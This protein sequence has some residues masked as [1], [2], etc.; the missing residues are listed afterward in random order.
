MSP[1]SSL[2]D[3][4]HRWLDSFGAQCRSQVDW[5]QVESNMAALS[6]CDKYGNESIF[7][8]GN[9]IMNA[10]RGKHEGD[11]RPRACTVVCDVQTFD[12]ERFT[13]EADVKDRILSYERETKTNFVVRKQDSTFGN[14]SKVLFLTIDDYCDNVNEIGLLG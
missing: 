1:F 2:L 13:T 6:A 12:M 3:N 10:T 4:N 11:S 14:A 5:T 8:L 9:P 7:N